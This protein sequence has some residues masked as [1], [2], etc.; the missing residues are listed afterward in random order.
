MQ[1]EIAELKKHTQCGKCGHVGH[2]K[3]ECTD[4]DATKKPSRSRDRSKEGAIS[5]V[6]NDEVVKVTPIQISVT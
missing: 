3:R 1:R 4:M 6:Q 2:W 5:G